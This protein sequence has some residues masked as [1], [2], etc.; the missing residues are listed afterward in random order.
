MFFPQI[1]FILTS[2]TKRGTN[3]RSMAIINTYLATQTNTEQPR[4]I[5]A[6]FSS[7][8][9]HG[10][11]WTMDNYALK[12]KS[13]AHLN[14][15]EINQ[16]LN[17]NYHQ[18]D[19]KECFKF[20]IFLFVMLNTP[21]LSAAL[22]TC[23][24]DLPLTLLWT[25]NLQLVLEEKPRKHHETNA[26]NNPTRAEPP[27]AITAAASQHFRSRGASKSLEKS[28]I[29]PIFPCNNPQGNKY[30]IQ[31]KGCSSSPQLQMSRSALPRRQWWVFPWADYSWN[32]H[33]KSCSIWHFSFSFT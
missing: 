32:L 19:R 16:R 27:T 12:F 25:W 21:S 29:N 18:S 17:I 5:Q 30:Q 28:Q 13:S 11:N 6:C 23:N 20:C 33:H 10:E 4:T 14:L 8:L 31:A 26:V 7:P 1:N 2:G 3:F 24:T 22:P 9:P 15:D